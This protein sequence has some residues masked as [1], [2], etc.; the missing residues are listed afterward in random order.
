MMAS[1]TKDLSSTTIRL[2]PFILVRFNGNE[3]KKVKLI[4]IRPQITMCGDM[5]YGITP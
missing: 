4:A 2:L 1:L 5:Y 3:H